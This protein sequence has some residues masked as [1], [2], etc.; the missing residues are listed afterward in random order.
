MVEDD[1]SPLVCDHKIPH[2]GDERLF[3]DETNLQSLLKSCH[4]RTNWKAEQASLIQRG[5]WYGR[6]SECEGVGG[7]QFPRTLSP[8][9]RTPLSVIPM[10]PGSS[11]ADARAARGCQTSGSASQYLSAD[12]G[13]RLRAVGDGGI[14]K[15][16]HE[17][18]TK[19]G[20]LRRPSLWALRCRCRDSGP[21]TSTGST[22]VHDIK[23][24]NLR[25][26]VRLARA[27]GPCCCSAHQSPPEWPIVRRSK[28]AP[29]SV[30]D[31]RG[32][33]R[34]PLSNAAAARHR[35]LLH[36]FASETWGC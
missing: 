16:L 36:L 15:R 23:G 14:I 6:P 1:A 30:D 11:D 22:T 20:P 4:D 8:T 2:R 27:L 12:A 29:G 21:L 9:D 32:C 3:W 19:D 31:V 5:V 7:R 25:I 10:A 18:I 33:G 17:T 26:G 34:S 13:L 28:S 24:E 35:P